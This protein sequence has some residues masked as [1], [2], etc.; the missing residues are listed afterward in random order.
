MRN[1]LTLALLV[2]LTLTFMGCD[3]GK[4]EKVTPVESNLP[5][6]SAEWIARKKDK[7]WSR[8]FATKEELLKHIKENP[9]D[10]AAPPEIE[11]R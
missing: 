11:Q 8:G 4:V 9:N 5:P 1:A 7:S 2:P 3:G 10:F 6:G